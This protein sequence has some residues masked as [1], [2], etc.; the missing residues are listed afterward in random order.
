M[1]HR[2]DT[3]ERR[4]KQTSPVPLARKDGK[5]ALHG[6]E[7]RAGSYVWTEWQVVVLWQEMGLNRR[8]NLAAFLL[9]NPCG[10]ARLTRI[11]ALT[12][13]EMLK[14]IEGTFG[15]IAGSSWRGME[16]DHVCA[17][18]MYHIN[19]L[20]ITTAVELLINPLHTSGILTPYTPMELLIPYSNY[21]TGGIV[22]PLHKSGFINPLYTPGWASLDHFG[23]AI[24]DS[25][26]CSSSVSAQR[27]EGDA[28]PGE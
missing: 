7:K 3:L 9:S 13:C 28:Q 23:P 24:C 5:V 21:H 14:S 15:S 8:D 12:W 18:H 1:H 16:D 19:S 20:V 27:E 11:A 22:D 25:W 4:H 6:K 26:R 17:H 10:H 2:D